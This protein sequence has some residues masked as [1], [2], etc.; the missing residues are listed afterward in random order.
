MEDNLNQKKLNDLKAHAYDILGS[1]EQLQ[2]A[3]N[4]TNNQIRELRKTIE[5][6]KIKKSDKNLKKENK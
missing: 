6:E 5:D 4:S 3:L 2:A 1:M